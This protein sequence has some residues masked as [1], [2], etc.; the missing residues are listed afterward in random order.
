VKLAL[1]KSGAY[2]NIDYRLGFFQEFLGKGDFDL[3][4]GSYS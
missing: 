2:A 3:V 1:E 4:L